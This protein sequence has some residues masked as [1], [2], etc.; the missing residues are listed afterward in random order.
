MAAVI[1][2]EKI[3]WST[4]TDVKSLFELILDM[5]K[6]K[7]EEIRR[8]RGRTAPEALI[9][10]I[11]EI[12]KE[13]KRLQAEN[14]ALSED[15]G[16]VEAM[17]KRITSLEE[18]S[19]RKDEEIS[20]EGRGDRQDQGGECPEGRGDRKD[21]E[22]GR[23]QAE[24]KSLREGGGAPD[25]M[26]ERMRVLERQ[27]AEKDAQLQDA[28]ATNSALSA[29]NLGIKARADKTRRED[30]AD[31]ARAD[32][33]Y[34][35]IVRPR[36][37]PDRAAPSVRANR[38]DSVCVRHYKTLDQVECPLHH[39]PLPEGADTY[40]RIVEDILGGEL[41][42]VEYEV[43]R[44]Y[45]R[46]CRRSISPDIPDTIPNERFGINLMVLE[47]TMKMFGIPYGIIRN[48]ICIIYHTQ[49]S[50]STV[51]HHVD[52]TARS[53]YPLYEAMLE[54]I[55]LSSEIHGDETSWPVDGDMW[56]LW[57]I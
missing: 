52:M 47:T 1:D 20:P 23:L 13:I 32:R 30:R 16:I 39:C 4:V 38:N 21:E 24:I 54:E 35:Q 2:L 27:V 15:H 42:A 9:Q 53:L 56:W 50:K 22:I 37:G 14:A 29:E 10:E 48:L 49:I 11:S 8:L 57:V 43:A 33:E 46:Y 26:S 6:S 34:A 31:R 40:K 55:T 17:G 41:V 7:D 5:L 51:M 25:A 19:A 18:E 36:G 3:D 28:R 12:R 45:C 44:R